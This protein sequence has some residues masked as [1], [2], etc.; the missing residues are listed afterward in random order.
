MDGFE[1]QLSLLGKAGKEAQEFCESQVTDCSDCY[2]AENCPVLNKLILR[3]VKQD[4]VEQAWQNRLYYADNLEVLQ[5]LLNDSS[6]CGQVRL[7]YIDPPFGT[8]QSFTISSNRYATI[9][10]SANGST[11]YH[12][13][14]VGKEYLNFL[15]LRLELLKRLLADDGSIYVH[16]DTKIG[17]YVKVLLD[18]IFGISNFR[19]D[20]TR[21]KSNPKNFNQN[22]Y[23]NFKDTILFYTKGDRFVWHQPREPFLEEEL[24]RLFPKIDS[25]GRRYTTTPLHAPGETKNGATGQ[26]WN[27]LTPP[28]GRHWRYAPDALSE[29]DRENLIE[30]SSKGNPRKKI[31]AD[32]ALKTGKLLQDVWVFKDPQ[33]PRY[34]TE[35]NLDMLKLIVGAS[36]NPGDIV[37][38]CFCGSGGTLV[39]AE[40]M[41]RRWIGIDNSELAI[42]ICQERLKVPVILEGD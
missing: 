42:K 41:E 24:L 8:G 20:I 5:S 39:A 22:G 36:S 30:W 34:P 29:L 27:G 12:D 18:E 13:N 7:V 4:S 32:E 6:V 17:H 2:K 31:F 26:P 15:R 40:E 35:K 14:L 21:I 33:Y 38:D 37:M 9:S 23:S 25:D 28:T 10:R 11:A 19:S 1:R 3:D 16:I